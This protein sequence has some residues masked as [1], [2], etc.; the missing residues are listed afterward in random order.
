MMDFQSDIDDDEAKHRACLL[1]EEEYEK[2]IAELESEL[3]KAKTPALLDADVEDAGM[4]AY[5]A[6][7]HDQELSNSGNVHCYNKIRAAL[8]NRVDMPPKEL[9]SVIN[10]KERI[11][12][13]EATR[14]PD[15]VLEALCTVAPTNETIWT[16]YGTDYE[17]NVKKGKA[18]LAK[19]KET[20]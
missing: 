7:L 11:A 13:L 6:M 15:E 2:R 18:I 4:S 14:V 16:A 20:T 10:M 9:F 1:R 19:R 3:T 5:L 17:R 12:E 8:A